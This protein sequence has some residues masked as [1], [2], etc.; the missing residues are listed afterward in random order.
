MRNG[1]LAAVAEAGG[2]GLRAMQMLPYRR[3]HQ[4]QDADFAEFRA[5]RRAAGIER[6]L[7]HSRY[8]PALAT[9][10]EPRRGNTVRH[11]VRELAMARKLAADAYV[12]HVGAYAPGSDFA[13]GLALFRRSLAEARGEAGA[14][15]LYI[16][17]VPG[18]GRR[19]GATA[20]ELGELLAAAR[21]VWPEAALCLDTA[22]A[23]AAGQALESFRDLAAA[24]QAWHLNDSLAEFGSGLES[25]WHLGQGRIGAEAL[26]ALLRRLAPTDAT[27]ILETPKGPGDDERNVRW[28][29]ARLPE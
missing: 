25:H 26:G 22:H 3:H 12:L 5:A 19:M 20:R 28:V 4:P 24:V 8:L 16:E 10:D 9:S 2:L 27:V 6:L 21:S 7:V 1:Y 14:L 11:L 18:G 29:T 13:A 15:P 17:N 23:W